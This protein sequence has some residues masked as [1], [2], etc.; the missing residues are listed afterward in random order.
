MGMDSHIHR[1]NVEVQ[2]TELMTQI[3]KLGHQLMEV[4]EK[5]HSSANA[6]ANDTAYHKKMYESKLSE[7]EKLIEELRLEVD[8]LGCQVSEYIDCVEGLEGEIKDKDDEVIR[9]KAVVDETKEQMLVGGNLAET[10]EEKENEVKT[11]ETLIA[12]YKQREENGKEQHLELKNVIDSLRQ[13]LKDKD[14]KI[15]EANVLLEECREDHEKTKTLN[16]LVEEKEKEIG[17]MA[18]TLSEEQ[19]IEAK[20]KVVSLQN[21][22]DSLQ[23]EN[24][25][26]VDRLG[27]LQMQIDSLEKDVADKE[28]TIRLGTIET[29]SRNE[30]NNAESLK[31]KEKLIEMEEMV[32]QRER[33]LKEKENEMS[34]FSVFHQKEIEKMNLKIQTKAREDR[35]VTEATLSSLRHE[36]DER[37]SI[38][39]N[40]KKMHADNE[41]RI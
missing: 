7:K 13:E 38:L 29:A 31:Y 24:K 28:E 5:S 27:T 21:D 23:S 32:R 1:E 2:N 20:A 22:V 26:Y 33:E 9:L 4:N 6:A 16:K 40:Y 37:D 35:E 30:Q 8:S 17:R 25:Y 3:E 34:D 19:L 39:E 36:I 41:I 11:L 12:D 18:H 14:D 15:H 10:I